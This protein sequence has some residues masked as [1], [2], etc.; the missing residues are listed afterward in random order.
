M[1]SFV[2]VLALGCVAVCA[3]TIPALAQDAA[4]ADADHHKVVFENEQ[5][6]VLKYVI[7]PQAKTAL[8]EHPKNVQ[9][10]LTDTNARV[11]TPDGKTSEVHGKAGQAN[12]RN[13]TKHI[14]E[15][16]GDKP[17]EGI[18][19]EPKNTGSAPALVEAL[20]PVV[21]DAP[22]QKLE[23]ENDQVRVLRFK[24]APHEKSVMHDHPNFVQILLTDSK[25]RITTADGKTTESQV[26]AGDANWR[27]ATKHTVENIGDTPIEGIIVELK[28][29]SKGPSGQN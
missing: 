3:T 11:T 25:A 20:D 17:I 16:I 5:V 21:V 18:L 1:R 13:P 7:A 6:R 9:V 27:S 29:T 4:T 2:T 12:W 22:H 14:V 23:F 24:F 10:M 15:N 26:K 28:G 19:V 8:H